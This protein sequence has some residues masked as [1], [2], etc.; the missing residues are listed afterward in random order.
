MTATGEVM[1]E[2]SRHD[3]ATDLLLQ[4]A[5]QPVPQTASC[6]QTGWQ[7]AQTHSQWDG[8]TTVLRAVRV[9]NNTV[10][11]AT[12]KGSTI[13]IFTVQTGNTAVS[14]S[15]SPGARQPVS[16]KARI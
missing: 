2:P 4:E 15:P 8:T 10:F 6:P 9:L 1:G 3:N 5:S 16:Y 11:M 12:D 13:I 7:Q 14:S